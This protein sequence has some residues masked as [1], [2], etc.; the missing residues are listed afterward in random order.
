MQQA[1]Q[2]RRVKRA[3]MIL[4]AIDPE[5]QKRL[6]DTS[7]PELRD[8][9]RPSGEQLLA[10]RHIVIANWP[11]QGQSQNVITAI[12]ELLHQRHITTTH[13]PE[14]DTCRSDMPHLK[15]LTPSD[16]SLFER[17]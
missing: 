13:V 9:F 17:I 5:V 7:H 4:H 8:H 12:G 1:E 11:I 3:S 2:R 16:V 6:I 10:C 14:P 15:R